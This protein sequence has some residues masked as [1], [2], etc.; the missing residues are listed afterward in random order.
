[1]RKYRIKSSPAFNNAYSPEY[2]VQVKFKYIPVW[3][4]CTFKFHDLAQ[5]EKYIEL[6]KKEF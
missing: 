6:I 5:A 2:K 4:P 3:L 1:M